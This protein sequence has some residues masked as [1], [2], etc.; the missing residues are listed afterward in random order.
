MSKY[1]ATHNHPEAHTP[2]NNNR[3]SPVPSS[4]RINIIR[5]L[6]SWWHRVILSGARRVRELD[7]KDRRAPDFNFPR[8]KC[9]TWS[10]EPIRVENIAP[11]R[12]D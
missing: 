3:H 11:D 12:L 7:V 4:H 8:N 6:W 1:G 10:T 5:V 9:F 2:H